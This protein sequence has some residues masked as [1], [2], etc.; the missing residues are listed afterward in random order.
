MST[1]ASVWGQRIAGEAGR[2]V[3][4]YAFQTAGAAK[5]AGRAEASHARS[6]RV[7]EK[8]GMAEEGMLRAERMDAS[9]NRVDMAVYGLTREAWAAA[10]ENR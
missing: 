10:R 8:A 9:G 7:M 6:R 3:V 5:V 4:D 1:V 2:A